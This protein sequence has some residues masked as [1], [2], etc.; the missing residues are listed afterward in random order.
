MCLATGG[1]RE[2]FKV[3]GT[4]VS[5]EFWSQ[6]YSVNLLAM[7][8]STERFWEQ[9]VT[10]IFQEHVKTVTGKS[11]PPV[12]IGLRSHQKVWRWVDNTPFNPKM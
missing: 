3:W 9:L 12:W 6:I 5:H 11:P 4:F 8:P 7:K 1:F 10:S 2:A